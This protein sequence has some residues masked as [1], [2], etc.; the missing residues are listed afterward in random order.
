MVTQHIK[1]T[2]TIDTDIDYPYPFDEVEDLNTPNLFR[3]NAR[4]LFE[5][6]FTVGTIVENR[7]YIFD[8]KK[9]LDIQEP[10]D[11][12]KSALFKS[13]LQEEFWGTQ[14]QYLS[15]LDYGEQTWGVI[16]LASD[17]M[18][19]IMQSRTVEQEVLDLLDEP[20]SR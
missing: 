5:L 3:R 11:Q 20:I 9:K 6:D 17:D 8:G 12:S 7:N 2:V 1:T 15:F 14:Q 18:S 13:S 16:D 19:D 10:V 4:K